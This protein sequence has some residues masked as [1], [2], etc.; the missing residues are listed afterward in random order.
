MQLLPLTCSSEEV[1]ISLQKNFH[2]NIPLQLDV[3][4]SVQQIELLF[5]EDQCGRDSQ[6]N[7]SKS[8]VHNKKRQCVKMTMKS[9]HCTDTKML[10]SKLKE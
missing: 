10:P 7:L 6:T 8:T 5:S 1:L 9:A 3:V 4:E 2:R